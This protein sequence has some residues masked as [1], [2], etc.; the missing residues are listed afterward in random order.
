M[1]HLFIKGPPKERSALQFLFLH[2]R[3]DVYSR[4]VYRCVCEPIHQSTVHQSTIH[5]TSKHYTLHQSTIHHT[6]KHYTLYTKAL[7]TKA[8]YTNAD[9]PK[10]AQKLVL[11]MDLRSACETSPLLLNLYYLPL[12][13]QNRVPRDFS[14]RYTWLYL[15]LRRCH[16]HRPHAATSV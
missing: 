2:Y 10:Q 13:C 16:A 1:L 15:G 3:N 6:P 9:I 7:Y 4:G 12:S 5:H 14:R 8:L 11:E